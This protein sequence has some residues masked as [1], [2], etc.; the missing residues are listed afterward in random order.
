[1]GVVVDYH[2]AGLLRVCPVCLS[3]LHPHYTLHPAC[4]RVEVADE[5]MF[6]S[7]VVKVS[8]PWCVLSFS[9]STTKLVLLGTKEAQSFV[10]VCCMSNLFIGTHGYAYLYVHISTLVVAFVC[11]RTI[12]MRSFYFM[13]MLIYC[14]C[15]F[16]LCVS[17]I[18]FK[19]LLDCFMQFFSTLEYTIVHWY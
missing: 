11:E 13:H 7:V 17:H 4:G 10:C 5:V 16:R 1:M 6:V 19:G 3:C 12:F 15:M 2:C 8:S 14:V 18:A 9:W